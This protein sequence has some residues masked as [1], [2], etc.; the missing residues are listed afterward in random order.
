MSTE[1]LMPCIRCKR[2]TATLEGQSPLESFVEAQ[3]TAA[4]RIILCPECKEELRALMRRA[5]AGDGH[6]KEALLRE[7]QRFQ[8]AVFGV[9]CD[10]E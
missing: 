3:D 7:R 8:T 1:A 6:A 10:D 2:E 4:T 5:G 9:L